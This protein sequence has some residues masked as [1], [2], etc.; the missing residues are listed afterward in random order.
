MNVSQIQQIMMEQHQ[1]IMEIQPY[2]VV[3]VKIEHRVDIMVYYPV[4]Y[5]SINWFSSIFLIFSRVVKDFL[6]EVF[7]N[8]SYTPV[9]VLKN[10]L[11]INS[12]E[13]GKD[14]LIIK[15]IISNYLWFSCQY[16]RLQKCLQVGMRIE[17]VQNERRPYINPPIKHELLSNV[18]NNQRIRK[19][20]DPT[21]LNTV[22]K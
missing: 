2:Y 17:A 3:F 22:I 9:L 11:L 4:K 1:Q 16:C 5:E 20:S 19:S 15:N 7:V 6:N 14:E 10:V 12:C 13:I 21:S 18:L 8:K